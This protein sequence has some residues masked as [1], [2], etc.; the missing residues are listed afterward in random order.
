M[1]ARLK[2]LCHNGLGG[3][4]VAELVLMIV[5]VAALGLA[6]DAFRKLHQ[7]AGIGCAIE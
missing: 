3:F 1:D 5:P 2:S 7:R 4:F 6:L